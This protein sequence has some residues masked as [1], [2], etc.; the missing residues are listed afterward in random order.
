MMEYPENV[1]HFER[2]VMEALAEVGFEYGESIEK[3]SYYLIE[4]AD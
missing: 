4:F 1:G 3:D 2:G